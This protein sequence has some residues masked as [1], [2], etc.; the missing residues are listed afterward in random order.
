MSEVEEGRWLGDRCA[1]CLPQAVLALS[2]VQ[3]V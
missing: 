3:F 2:I 1:V